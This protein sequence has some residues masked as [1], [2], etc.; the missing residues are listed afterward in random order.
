MKI[1]FIILIYIL[2]TCLNNV[3]SIHSAK[4]QEKDYDKDFYPGIYIYAEEPDRDPMEIKKQVKER[5]KEKDY[6]KNAEKL[7]KDSV[8]S[9]RKILE[10]QKSQLG[11]IS[12]LQI[13]SGNALN[14]IVGETKIRFMPWN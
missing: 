5:K 13:K 3:F 10:L 6:I 4:K 7:D 2:T 1:Y 12:A 11:K 14:K 9:F 8:E